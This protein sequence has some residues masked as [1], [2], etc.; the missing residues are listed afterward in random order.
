MGSG[1]AIATPSRLQP[2]RRAAGWLIRRVAGSLLALAAV[3]IMVFLA[4]KAMPEDPAQIILGEM[5]RPEAI[6]DLRE[7]LGLDRPL[8]T[9][10]LEWVGGM[11][12]G[13]L[14]RSWAGAALPVGELVGP[15]LVNSLVLV[16][17]GSLFAIPLAVLLG[18]LTALWRNSLFDHLA[19][20]TLLGMSSIPEFAKG[21]FLVLLLSIGLFNL[22][23]AAAMIPPGELPLWY[24]AQIALP[25]LV[26]VLSAL[27]YLT[28]LVRS[29]MIDAL[30]SE[31]VQM[32]RLKGVSEARIL[33]RHALPNTAAP[34]IQGAALSTALMLGGSV[35]IENLFR[36]PGVG[37]LMTDAMTSRDLP[38]VQA[39]IVSF[40]ACYMVINLIAD[41]L[42]LYANPQY[43]SAR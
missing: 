22:L 18:V 37:A 26:L 3:T 17:L 20:Y 32:A 27:P 10:Y 31:Y 36:Y 9:Q 5:A 2:V 14:G 12:R 21:I 4:F 13:D 29:S 33:F 24:P 43:R 15:A 42:I 40:A 38:L 41:V 34:V 6:A 28:R 35:V 16:A 25:V 23:P 30:N 39:V 11:L 1:P 7:K 8:V 19:D